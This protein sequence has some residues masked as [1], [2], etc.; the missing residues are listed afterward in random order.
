[1]MVWHDETMDKS[2]RK[3]WPNIDVTETD[4]TQR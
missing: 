4:L 2:I 3:K 1:M